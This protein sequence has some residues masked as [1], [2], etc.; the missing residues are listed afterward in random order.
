MLQA[1]QAKLERAGNPFQ[2]A[3][4]V[5]VRVLV[6]VELY[7]EWGTYRVAIRDLDVSYTLGEVARRREEILRKLAKERLVERNKSLPFPLVPLRV[8]L[9]TSLGSDAERDVLKT[10]RESGFSFQVVVHGARVQGR[11]TEPTVLAALEWFRDHADEFDVCLLY[12]S[13]SPRD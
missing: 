12:T 7:V 13:P 5:T 2:L 6:Q 4:E 8:G 10:L 3:D 9:I 11:Y 1:I